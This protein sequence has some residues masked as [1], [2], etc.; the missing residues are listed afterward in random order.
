M[1]FRDTLHANHHHIPSAASLRQHCCNREHRSWGQ[2][3]EDTVH[4]SIL[5]MAKPG[6][7]SVRS[8]SKQRSATNVNQSI[9][10]NG[11]GIGSSG[12]GTLDIQTP[13]EQAAWDIEAISCPRI[14]ASFSNSTKPE[15]SH[16][17]A[18]KLLHK[19]PK[20]I[21]FHDPHLYMANVMRTR[22]A[23]G[24]KTMA[25]PDFWGHCPPPTAQ[26]L[27]DRKLGV[28]R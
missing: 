9:Q 24:F 8:S 28:Q 5:H 18:E 26:P 11:L 1:N 22:S 20:H 3:G 7:S 6:K 21:P 10:Q 15:E 19:H 17:A 12:R 23:V 13:L 14:T 4:T 16:E 25:F 2:E 27:L